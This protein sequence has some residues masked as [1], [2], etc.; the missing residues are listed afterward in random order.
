ML[1]VSVLRAALIPSRL[2][3]GLLLGED[4]T[5][6]HFWVEFFVPAV[7]WVPAD[8]FL[9][10][11]GFPRG[12]KEP[13]SPSEFYFGNI[14]SLRLAFHHGSAENGPVQRDGR[15][16]A[17]PDP[18]SA[19]RNYLEVGSAIQSIHVDWS[20][21]RLLSSRPWAAA[22]ETALLVDSQ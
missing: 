22:D 4:E 5:Y 17:P 9:G 11:G 8:P 20:A 18:F 6:P 10:D 15:P 16:I 21:P 1:L 12:L 19:Q 7:G 3:G 13:A 2:V 14:D